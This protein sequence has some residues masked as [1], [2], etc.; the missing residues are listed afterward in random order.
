MN[1]NKAIP[2]SLWDLAAEETVIDLRPPDMTG[3][4]I[5]ILLEDV[6]DVP[7]WKRE[8]SH[9]PRIRIIVECEGSRPSIDKLRQIV[10]AKGVDE[11]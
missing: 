11:G 9:H 2:P 1:A 8:A 3:N 10:M 4:T 7:R 6:Q 5:A